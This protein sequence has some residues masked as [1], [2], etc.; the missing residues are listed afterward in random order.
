MRFSLSELML[1]AAGITV[2]APLVGTVVLGMGL[3]R[4]SPRIPAVVSAV[5]SL[6]SSAVLTILWNIGPL[7]PVEIGDRMGGG[8]LVDIDGV[9]GLLLPYVALVHLA[10]V[11]VAPRR[12]FD[13]ASAMRILIGSGMTLALFCTAHPLAIVGLWILTAVPTWFSIRAMPG[14]RPVARVYCIAMFPAVV[15]MTLGTCMLVGDPPWEP[16]S[17]TIGNV[18]GWLVAMAVL[19]RKGIVPFHSWYPA[20]FS[21]APM[22]TAL[23]ATMPQVAA[24]TAI[25]LL[26]GHADGVGWELIVLSQAALITAAYG[27]ALATVQKDVKGLVGTLAM[28]QSAMVLAGLSGTVAMELN[29]ALCVWISSGVSLTGLGLVAWAIESRAGSLSIESLQGRF[30]DA[31]LLAAF[32]LLFGLAI[33]GVPGTLSFVADDLIVSGC[34]DD[35]LHAGLFVIAATVLSGIAVLRGWFHVFGGP[36]AIDGP[37]HGILL[38]ERVAML[39][40]LAVLLFFGLF[41]GRLVHSLEQA[42]NSLM[43]ESASSEGHLDFHVPA[44]P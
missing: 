2:A 24:Y 16:G 29:G 4:S 34:L 19:V 22:S 32:F 11:L 26:V 27:A 44:I 40:L 17:G 31:P 1:L 14:G 35:Q 13:V 12:F 36:V 20:L 5:V 38:R 41:P 39:G 42:A 21:A 25:R 15:C 30:R 28:S 10:I 23:A 9:T 3:F 18:G 43:N 6:V 33:I 8:S 7:I 37:S